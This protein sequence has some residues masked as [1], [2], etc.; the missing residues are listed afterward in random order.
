[1]G[2]AWHRW[3][4]FGNFLAVA[5]SDVGVRARHWL[6]REL[7]T[8]VA[9]GFRPRLSDRVDSS[10][11]VI[12][13]STSGA[14]AVR[15]IGQGL[16]MEHTIARG[17][18]AW[19]HVAADLLLKPAA[20][21]HT[22]QFYE[23]ERFLVH[24]IARYLGAG[25]A[26]HERVLAILTPEHSRAVVARLEANGCN[27][28]AALQNGSLVLRDARQTLSQFMVGGLLD[29]PL[30]DAQLARTLSELESAGRPGAGIRAYGEM[31]NL[32]ACDGNVAAAVQLEELWN[33]ASS[34]HSFALLCAYSIEHFQ[35]GSARD[36]FA[37][38]VARHSHVLPT[39]EFC[40]LDDDAASL[41]EISLLQQ[42]AR[43]V[44]YERR[45]RKALEQALSQAEAAKALFE[46]EL[47]AAF[48]REREARSR[49]EASH[50]FKE[51][52]LGM[53]G[54]DLRGPLDTILTTLRGVLTQPELEQELR[55]KLFRVLSSSERMQRMVQQ[56]L[57]A[58]R[59][60]LSAGIPLRLDA[61]DLVPL[62]RDAV[63]DLRAAH[64]G[65]EIELSLPENCCA[66]IDPERFA[67]VLANLLNNAIVHGDPRRPICV[68]AQV[69]DAMLSVAVQ[70]F[71]AIDPQTLALLFDPWKR[72][73]KPQAHSAGLG[74]GLY[75]SQHL[76][77]AHGGNITVESSASSGTRFEI[78]L[79]C[80]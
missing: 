26:A 44:D 76:V 20:R 4:C 50:A 72:G 57:D 54:H 79:P 2:S 27:V 47:R 61:N 39:E 63:S 22:V 43:E 62:I 71:G 17:S 34:R 7:P 19:A 15:R 5:A 12:E 35:S 33:D 25:L 52:F 18:D 28:R 53:L 69:S 30:F 23:G 37:E 67:Q 48:W 77:R 41:R 75:I 51:V 14:R 65:R 6:L 78:R 64:H 11:Q 45:Q 80:P 32:L 31:V 3:P 49:V 70:N 58:T 68:S 60:R 38:V 73:V 29:R 66:R 8:E 10:A 40:E 16:Y 59:A 42:R 21:T 24:T 1:M 56:I 46:D 13:L 74:L 55:R 36:Q 9:R